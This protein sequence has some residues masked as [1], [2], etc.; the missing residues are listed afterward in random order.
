MKFLVSFAAEFVAVFDQLA[1]AGAVKH[2][3]DATP[4]ALAENNTLLFGV[5]EEKKRARDLHEH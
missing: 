1:D 3:L 5:L 4:L 2:R